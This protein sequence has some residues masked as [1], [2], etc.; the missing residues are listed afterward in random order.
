MDETFKWMKIIV[1]FKLWKIEM[2][3]RSIGIGKMF[4]Y[5]A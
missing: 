5:F 3:E 4:K 2:D 1:G